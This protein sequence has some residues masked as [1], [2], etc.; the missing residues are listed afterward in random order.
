MLCT[1]HKKP[2]MHRLASAGLPD[3]CKCG[4]SLVVEHKATRISKLKSGIIRTAC[5]NT[6]AW[7]GLRNMKQRVCLSQLDGLQ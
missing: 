5:H 1:E 7:P 3:I 4:I 2:S 6:H